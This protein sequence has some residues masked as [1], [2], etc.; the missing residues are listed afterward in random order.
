MRTLLAILALS[1]LSGCATLVEPLPAPESL[2]AGWRGAPVAE[3]PAVAP[4]WKAF[5]D[6]TLDALV[7][8]AL[9]QNTDVRQAAARVAQARALVASA[10][11][12]QQPSVGVGLG[13]NRR[14]YPAQRYPGF[15]EPVPAATFNEVA[16]GIEAA[17]EIDLFG[18]LAKGVA[19]AQ[20]EQRATEWDLRAA[21]LAVAR[22][23]VA[24]Y[25]DARVAEARLSEIRQLAATAAALRAT[26]GRLV[27]AGLG[28][29][30]DARDA[31]DLA[32]AA[33]LSAAQL[34]RTHAV[35]IARLGVLLDQAPV[36]VKMGAP[37]DDLFAAPL[38][39]SVDLPASVIERRPDV[40]AAWQRL[41]GATTDIERVRLERYPRLSLTGALGFASNELHTWLTRNALAWAIGAAASMPLLDGGRIDAR[42][43]GAVAVRDQYAAAYRRA[44]V[45]ALGEVEEALAA[46]QAA[47]VELDAQTDAL[48][49]RARDRHEAGRAVAL[50]RS[51]A[52]DRL[53]DEV[54]VLRTQDALL[55][56][57][58]ERI[59]AYAAIQHALAQ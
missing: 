30:R 37:S 5:G 56:A 25:A 12:E 4:W 15:P 57:Q 45:V 48:A 1:A 9:Q 21:R 31:D 14:R 29:T 41:S 3:T 22:D 44:V 16:G 11:A 54:A 51:G 19:R 28:T 58:F 40:Q 24:A 49:R 6:T 50:G 53:R 36:D 2:P 10:R 18:R 55:A 23:V 26:E 39:V 59:A 35:A 27:R 43:A 52:R 47:S 42:S 13:A 17:Y 8:E 38:R 7:D 20:D 46:W 32:A 34:E 33:A